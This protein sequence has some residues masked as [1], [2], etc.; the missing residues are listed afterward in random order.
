VYP[1]L[2]FPG[3]AASGP[4]RT[5]DEHVLI[6]KANLP[7]AQTPLLLRAFFEAS[8]NAVQCL[9]SEPGF[10]YEHSVDALTETGERRVTPEEA[11]SGLF[12]A[13]A[14]F[15]TNR[16]AGEITYGDREFFINMV[17]GPKTLMA[18]MTPAFGLWEWSAAFGR[19]DPRANG[20]QLV[21]TP[22][23]VR[24]VVADLGAVLTDIWP[25]VATAGADGIATIQ[26]ARARRRQ[27]SAD[28]EAE[29]DHRH[30]AAQAAEAF[31]N[32]DYARV[33]ALLAPITSRLTDAERTKLRL[34]R[35]FAER[36]DG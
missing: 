29:R 26:S 35:K 6:W 19:P 27:E 24:A 4:R 16:V 11:A 28:A 10:K 18:R 1:G 5:H 9:A 3:D 2:S 20:D 12:F 22:D 34:A 25:K 21:V 17:L 7:P 13:G 36:S 14:R 23:R 31:R 30:F 33:I 8:R 32:R 15:A